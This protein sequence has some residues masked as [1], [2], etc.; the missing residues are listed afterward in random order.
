M[1]MRPA[2]RT[3][4]AALLAIALAWTGPAA[5]ETATLARGAMDFV[6]MPLDL[7]LMPYT[8]TS[9]LVRKF[10]IG[11]KQSPL[12]KAMLTPVMAIAYG[13]CCMMLTGAAAF[14]RLADGM[15]NVPVGLASLGADKEPD[16]ALY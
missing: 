15:L 11:G 10:Y 9:T 4:T 6:G 2:R 8:A 16:T 7:A 14:M 12:E 1:G 5:A 13:P 3:A